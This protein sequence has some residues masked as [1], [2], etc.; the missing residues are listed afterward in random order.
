MN[1]SEIRNRKEHLVQLV[2]SLVSASSN[3]I[4]YESDE[5]VNFYN[6][7]SSLQQPEITILHK[8][9]DKLPRMSMLDIGVGA[10]RT[11]IHFAPLV[12]R[13][14]GIDYSNKMI[15]VCKKKF[16][17]YPSNVTFLTSDAR[18]LKLFERK[19][20]D[21]VLFS[22]NGID[23][24]RHEDRLET[25]FEIRQLLKSG[26][27]FCFSTH[28]LNYLLNMCSIKL[29]KHPTVLMPHVF[30]VLQMR[31]L[32]T[33]D[34]WHTI[35]DSSRKKGYS[36]INDGAHHFRLKTYY[37]TPIEQLRQL[38]EKGYKETRMY[39]LDGKEIRDP[40]APRDQWIYFLSRVD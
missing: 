16:K 20:F 13:Y 26:G 39:G 30:N 29:S 33:S 4:V 21:F 37:V 25:L 32:N 14:L 11:T 6:E 23:Y 28:N 15:I 27:Y 9:R 1:F 34:G 7:L 10:G 12:N 38:Q 31:L 17:D 35:R 19:S 36:L 18:T 5:V 3:K 2:G 24:M 40:L 8:L 22:F